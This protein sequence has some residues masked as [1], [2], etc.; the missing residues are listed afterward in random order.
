[1]R[2]VEAEYKQKRNLKWEVM[3][4]ILYTVC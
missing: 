3:E 1:M 2:E 4:T